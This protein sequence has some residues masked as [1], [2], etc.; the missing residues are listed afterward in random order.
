MIASVIL[1]AGSASRM[2]KPKQLLPLGGRPM[3]WWAANAA[4]RAALG[5]VIVVT[6]AYGEEVSRA[7]ADL[8]VSVAVNPHWQ[9]GQAASLKAGLA[10][11]DR[12]AVAVMY[13]LADQPLIPAAVL[14]DI[15]RAYYA[16]QGSIVAPVFQGQRGNPVLFDLN[17]WRE[18][19]LTLQGDCGAREILRT[20]PTELGCVPVDAPHYFLDADTEE[21]YQTILRHWQDDLIDERNASRFCK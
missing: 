17:R 9:S 20:H 4:C 11:V 1:A 2:G 8:A 19:L 14:Q 13:L 3:V 15:A 12:Q 5:Q 7:L 21:D 18:D 6:G 10:T 16:G